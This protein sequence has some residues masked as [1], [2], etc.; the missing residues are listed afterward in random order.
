MHEAAERAYR[1]VV[2]RVD[3]LF[4]LD[5]RRSKRMTVEELDQR[6][7]LHKARDF[8]ALQALNALDFIAGPRPGRGSHP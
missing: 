6:G 8:G 4:Q 7:T 1:A 3:A 5:R 2:E